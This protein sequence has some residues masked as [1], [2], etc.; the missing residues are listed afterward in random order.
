[1]NAY[2]EAH[3]G[4]AAYPTAPQR[5]RSQPHLARR[6]PTLD[7]GRGEGITPAYCD[8]SDEQALGA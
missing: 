8:A 1:M 6:R 5:R 3:L 4:V 7:I 2:D